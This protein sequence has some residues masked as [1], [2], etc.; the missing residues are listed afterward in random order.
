MTHEQIN[1]SIVKFEE[2]LF[3]NQPVWNTREEYAIY[4]NWM[5]ERKVISNA[6]KQALVAGNIERAKEIANRAFA[7]K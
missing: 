5:N 1:K 4:E 2:K 6:F 3:A 7:T